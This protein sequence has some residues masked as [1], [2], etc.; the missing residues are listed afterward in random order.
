MDDRP[1]HANKG[2]SGLD[3]W[4]PWLL[5]LGGLAFGLGWILGAVGLW[6]SRTWTLQEKV[7]ATLVWPGGFIAP[8]YALLLTSSTSTVGCKT[9]DGIAHC[10]SHSLL[11][12]NTPWLTAPL[13]IVAFGLP[14]LVTVVLTRRLRTAARGAGA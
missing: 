10:E 4:I 3:G 2:P 8:Y 11:L 9:A 6:A 1:D 7:L 5:L 12:P 14:V 13:V